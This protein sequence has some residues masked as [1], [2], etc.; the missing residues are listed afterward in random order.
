MRVLRRVDE[1]FT[2]PARVAHG[3]YGGRVLWHWLESQLQTKQ[4][5]MCVKGELQ[6]CTSGTTC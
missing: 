6:M 2:D 3:R 1:R 4:T 5:Y